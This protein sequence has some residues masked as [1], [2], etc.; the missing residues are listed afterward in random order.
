MFITPLVHC[1]PKLLHL[2]LHIG[3]LQ[4]TAC[5]SGSSRSSVCGCP[6][7]DSFQKTVRSR[8]SH[9]PVAR[10][11]A[12]YDITSSE[13]VALLLDPDSKEPNRGIIIFKSV[14]KTTHCALRFFRGL[15][16]VIS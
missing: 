3:L 4:R 8:G 9:F 16:F 6:G 7:L 13:H 10:D 14:G 12:S 11:W 1:G 5:W 15:Q 2:P